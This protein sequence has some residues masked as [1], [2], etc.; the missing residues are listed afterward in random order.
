[1]LISQP[2]TTQPTV[3]EVELLRTSALHT[4]RQLRL[5]LCVNAACIALCTAMWAL[6]WSQVD[7]ASSVGAGLLSF[8]VGGLNAGAAWMNLRQF[9]YSLHQHH[10]VQA[11]LGALTITQKAIEQ[12][13]KEGAV[14]EH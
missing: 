9:H 4:R 3:Q 14:N 6:C 2:M 12:M 1:M 11:I 7:G 8:L 13:N 10:N 5:Y